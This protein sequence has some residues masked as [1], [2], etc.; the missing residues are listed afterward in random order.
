MK[1]VLL[2]V[3][4]VAC[5]ILVGCGEK[6]TTQNK[7]KTN[8]TIETQVVENESATKPENTNIG[9][10]EINEETKAQPTE[11]VEGLNSDNQFIFDFI[12][13][14]L[15]FTTRD[16]KKLFYIFGE[17][18][19]YIVNYGSKNSTKY[20]SLL[21]IKGEWKLDGTTLV[22]NPNECVYW[23]PNE[24]QTELHLEYR[25]YKL[26][27]PETFVNIVKEV[28]KPTTQEYLHAE[29]HSLYLSKME[30]EEY[31]KE[32]RYYLENDLKDIDI[33]K[34]PTVSIVE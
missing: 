28:L 29:G 3:V 1:K 31:I 7:E 9:N 26:K 22:L 13:K 10:S 27:N 32:V 8:E 20:E 19:K 11:K 12:T 4:V 17:D 34:L 23:V 6:E 15:V 25:D 18:G 33:E 30:D 5:A 2:L 14:N 21:F 24:E 16:S